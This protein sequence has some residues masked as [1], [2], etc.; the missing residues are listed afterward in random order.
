MP[1]HLEQ[2][3]DVRPHA[4]HP[5]GRE[6]AREPLRRLGARGG[7]G[8]HLGEH[9]VVVDGHRRPGLD[10]ALPADARPV[11]LLPRD[12]R[13]G[14][15]QEVRARVLGVDARLD[16]VPAEPDV[17]LPERQRLAPGDQD[18]Q[19]DEIEAGHLL[20]HRVLDLEPGVHLEEV[21]GARGVQDELDGAG[22][23]VA[24]RPSRGDRR[25]AHPPPAL[26][27]E[28][29]R[30]R[31][32]D[33][34]LMTALDRALALEA[35]DERPVHVAEDLDLHVPRRADV[36]FDEE[37]IVAEGALRLA[38]RRLERRRQPGRA[39]DQPHAFSAPA[40]RGLHEDRVPDCLRALG[41]LPLVQALGAEPRDDGHAGRRHDPLR[42][43][44]AAHP[45]DGVGRW[46][47]EDDAR[48]R[49][50]LREVRVLREEAVARV[51]RVRPGAPRHVEHPLDRQEG[52]A[53]DRRADGDR[54]VGGAD[55]GRLAV[56]VGVDRDCRDPHR[57]AGAHDAR[58]DL[59]AVGDQDLRDPPHGATSG[60][61]RR[62]RRP[63]RPG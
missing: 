4:V 25:G 22:V 57:A 13:A 6:R 5:R 60:R 39:V 8:D 35:V 52:R 7:V 36:A 53:R 33:D 31:L 55:E 21:E 28:R 27:V 41:D 61:R 50:G 43:D 17:V 42:L 26:V 16:R 20:G 30:R 56:G 3:G 23:V 11:G 9:R 54:L 46:A 14:R 59:A 44:L 58:G 34:L 1:Q 18:L 62:C 48:L 38:P 10:P 32:L 12:Q 29:R 63:G 47:D 15:G 49:A 40:G 37:R 24:D 45:A 51:D 19:A 2:E